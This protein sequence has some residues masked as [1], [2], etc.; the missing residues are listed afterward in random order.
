MDV[1]P[2]HQSCS[3]KMKCRPKLLALLLKKSR[4][5]ASPNFLRIK[6]SN[7]FVYHRL[8]E[9]NAIVLNTIVKKALKKLCDILRQISNK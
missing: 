4:N 3:I 6:V 8:T 1:Y 7:L 5:L 9:H 2:Y